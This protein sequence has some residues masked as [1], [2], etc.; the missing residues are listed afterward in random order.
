MSTFQQPKRIVADIKTTKDI[1]IDILYRMT[2]V[3]LALESYLSISL[4]TYISEIEWLTSFPHGIYIDA[5]LG[6][7]STLHKNNDIETI[8]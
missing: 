6:A 1:N 2:D 3:E 7:I 5:T 8:S 4:A